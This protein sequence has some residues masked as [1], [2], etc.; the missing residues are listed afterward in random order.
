[1]DICSRPSGEIQRK[2]PQQ[3]FELIQRVGSGTYGDVYKA[4]N[5][6]TGELAAVKIIKLEPGELDRPAIPLSTYQ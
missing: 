6:Q 2:N 5:I 4:R 1:M 3:D